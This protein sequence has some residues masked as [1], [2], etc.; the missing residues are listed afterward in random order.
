MNIVGTSMQ[1]SE[2]ND[3]NSMKTVGTSIKKSMTINEKH[4]KLD[5]TSLKPDGKPWI[6]DTLH[7]F[8]GDSDHQ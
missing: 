3:Q 5:E 2:P 8:D 6:Y 4:I 1:L 7:S